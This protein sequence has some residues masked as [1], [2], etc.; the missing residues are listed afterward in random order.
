MEQ[1][2]FADLDSLQLDKTKRRSI[3]KLKRDL[4][5]IIMNALQDDSITEIMLNPS[6]DLYVENRE[7]MQKVGTMEPGYSETLIKVIASLVSEEVG[8][9]NPLIECELPYNGSRFE[10]LLQPIVANPSFTIRKHAAAIYTLEDYVESG[11]LSM[12]QMCALELAV[13]Q[14]KNILVAGSTGSGKTTFT[15]AIIKCI[16][17][18]HPEHRLIVIEDTNELQISENI[19]SVTV[20]SNSNFSMLKA[21]KATMR[22]RPDRIIV[23]EVRGGEALTL[24]K[25]WNTGHE[26]GCCTVHAN[27]AAAALIRVEQLISEESITPMHNLIAEAIDVIVFIQKEET[28]Q[29]GRTIKEIMQLGCYANGQYQLTNI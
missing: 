22:L 27:S 12:N 5:P 15:N 26:G 11:I 4:G 21:L 19:N 13:K 28:H 25:S 6:K 16:E 7:G 14:R 3:E 10:G 23:G 18:V 1:L 24:L 20:R 29:A 8:A 9:F 2:L 17:A